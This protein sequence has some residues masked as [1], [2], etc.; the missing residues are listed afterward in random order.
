M[1]QRITPGQVLHPHA[2][3][4]LKALGLPRNV[5]VEHVHEG[6]QAIVGNVGTGGGTTKSEIQPHAQ[7]THAPESPMQSA[8]SQERKALQQRCD[9]ER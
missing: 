2:Q 4:R 7:V 3:L 5:K 8:L 9:E 1:A 6:G